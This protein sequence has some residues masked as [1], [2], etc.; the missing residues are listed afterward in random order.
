M[1]GH[2]ADLALKDA[3]QE[4]LLVIQNF[5]WETP[6]K[7][8]IFQGIVDI[9]ECNSLQLDN[10]ILL[11][12]GIFSLFYWQLLFQILTTDPICLQTVAISI[13]E[14]NKATRT[15]QIKRHFTPKFMFDILFC[16]FCKNLTL[17]T[18]NRLHGKF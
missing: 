16:Y 18:S 13:P 2:S 10:T 11:K 3:F 8:H 5:C 6:L 7:L 1:T 14:V 15:K 4:L 12:F 17:L 9:L